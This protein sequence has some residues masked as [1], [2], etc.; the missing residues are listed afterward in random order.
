M[1]ALFTFIFSLCLAVTVQAQT[2]GIEMAQRVANNFLKIEGKTYE[3][4]VFTETYVKT[5]EQDTTYYVLSYDQGFVIV[6]SQRFA[7]PVLGYSLEGA[8]TE[9]D[10]PDHVQGWYDHYADEIKYVLDH[11]Q[12]NVVAQEITDLW[13]KYTQSH[14]KIP[15]NRHAVARTEAVGK[16]I[17]TT[18][19]QGKYYN[20]QCP[21]NNCDRN[22]GRALV[23]CVA[24]AVAQIMRYHKYPAKG[25][26][27]KNHISLKQTLTVNFGANSYDWNAM[28][29]QLTNY[30][31]EVAK[32]LYHVGVA[33]EMGYGCGGS[34]TYSA[35]AREA[36]VN[37]FGYANTAKLVN[38]NNYT[39]NWENDLKKE[40]DANRPVYYSGLTPDN[41]SGHAFV[42]D[43]YDNAGMFHMNMGWGGLAD[44]YYKLNSIKT[45]NNRDYTY[46]Q[47]AIFGIRPATTTTSTANYLRLNP[48]TNQTLSSNSGSV[49]VN[50]SSN[51]SWTIS[52]TATAGATWVRYATGSSGSGTGNSIVSFNFDKN[53]ST[54]TRT[55]TLVFKANG[56]ADQT[57]V[58][59]QAAAPAATA[60]LN[61]SPT[62]MQTLSPTGG[63]ATVNVSSN[64]VWE[65]SGEATYYDGNIP[66]VGFS[67]D[68]EGTNN[69]S[70][71]ISFKPNN[72]LQERQITVTVSSQGLP[73][74]SVIFVQ[75]SNVSA[76][77]SLKDGEQKVCQT[78]FFDSGGADENYAQEEKTIMTLTPA[79]AGQRLQVKFKEFN[80]GESILGVF[81][82]DS[83]G[84]LIAS[85]TGETLPTTITATNSAG[86][87]TFAF[88][89]QEE[90]P[91]SGWVADITCVNPVAQP[92]MLKQGNISVCSGKLTEPGGINPYTDDLNVTTTLTPSTPNSQLRLSFSEFDLEKDYDFL[93]IYNGNSV[94]APLIGTYTGKNLPPVINANNSTGQLT[95]V[96]ISDELF[97]GSGFEATIS[98]VANPTPVG[99]YCTST[100]DPTKKDQEDMIARF[101]LAN[102]DNAS[103]GCANYSDFTGRTATLAAG[104]KTTMTLTLGSCTSK[105]YN[106]FVK[107]FID[108]NGNGNFN[109]EGYFYN[110]K[111]V[112]SNATLNWEVVVPAN[113]VQN[114]PV[115]IRAIVRTLITGE[116]DQQAIDRI[117]ACGTYPYGETED[118]SLMVVPFAPL[119]ATISASGATTFCKGGNVT[120]SMN[121]ASAVSN[122]TFQWLRNEQNIAG[123]TQSTYT[124]T[125]LG[126]YTLRASANGQTVISNSI[127]VT[128]NEIPSKPNLT[129]SKTEFCEKETVTV[130][131]PAGFEAY[132]WQGSSTISTSNI[133]TNATLPAGNYVSQV[134]VR[135][136]GCWSPLSDNLNFRV[137]PLPTASFTQVRLDGDKNPTLVSSSSVG[138]QWYLNN[139]PIAGANAQTYRTTEIGNYSLRV[140]QNN[141][142]AEA[143]P[144]YVLSNDESTWENEIQLFPNPTNGEIHLVLSQNSPFHTLKITN[145]LGQKVLEKNISGTKTS[146]DLSGYPQGVYYLQLSSDQQSVT[147]KFVLT[148]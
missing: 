71:G 30:N 54:T 137:N 99:T 7:Y 37:Y 134:R 29:D 68:T 12:G 2:V 104:Q 27:Q 50:I 44:T 17:S 102:L 73:N 16:M 139:N 10:M 47:S 49:S 35:K 135:Q 48:S 32:I 88:V 15:T 65:A 45:V 52:A 19:S 20:A 97:S 31:A 147:K 57:L 127:L 28:P 26:G 72:T 18:W 92:L 74:K 53:T 123:A 56:I 22:D 119:T 46:S 58:Y 95:L 120:L 85:F 81:D 143:P 8:Y 115:R 132:E 84:D 107:I 144:V 90:F 114:K 11:L 140:T 13:E 66:W 1:K 9:V 136:N 141:C 113:T 76:G 64:V 109:D 96:F 86:K 91:A 75:K 70:V 108:W 145:I 67:T 103:A 148:R 101:Q 106:N 94:S 131:A 116:T 14:V 33:C 55:L 34:S 100:S 36:F 82:G 142:T 60:F 117:T 40:I 79:T 146:L 129:I 133:I 23:G 121:N 21:Q 5:R 98:C 39:G 111:P 43:G 125:E 93:K 24:V 4:V 122:A 69:G 63:T 128:V 112:K 80:I 38:K 130:Q 3:D 87:L 42:C 110:D 126:N 77:I 61:I 6:A 62:T 105:S 41:K 83:N 89:S 138:N 124:A 59:T 25:T 118:Y 78:T 51:V